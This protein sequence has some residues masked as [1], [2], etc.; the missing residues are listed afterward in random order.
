MFRSAERNESPSIIVQG[1]DGRLRDSARVF[2]LPRIPTT[3]L[4]HTRLNDGN[5]TRDTV[6]VVNH[7]GGVQFSNHSLMLSQLSTSFQGTGLAQIQRGIPQHGRMG[8]MMLLP[9]NMNNISL[10]RN[11]LDTSQ[12]INRISGSRTNRDTDSNGDKNSICHILLRILYFCLMS[13]YLYDFCADA[14]LSS[15][16]FVRGEI[17]DFILL[18]APGTTSALVSII[19]IHCIATTHI[20]MSCCFVF[21]VF[22]TSPITKALM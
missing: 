9:E 1:I 22:V 16:Y 6:S 17:K 10:S 12:R 20:S 5:V 15:Q 14:V 11:R 2:C 19:I 13:V 18:I 7:F 4:S 21:L 8:H 3:S